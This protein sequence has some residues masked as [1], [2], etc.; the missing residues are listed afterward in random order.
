MA[1]D[2]GSVWIHYQF[3]TKSSKYFNFASNEQ[4]TVVR[5]AFQESVRLPEPFA[6]LL[7]WYLSCKPLTGF[8]LLFWSIKGQQM[9]AS[10]KPDHTCHDFKASIP[11]HHLTRGSP[12]SSQQKGSTTAKQQGNPLPSESGSVDASCVGMGICLLS[13]LSPNRFRAVDSLTF[14]SSWVTGSK[15]LKYWD[16]KQYLSSPIFKDVS[17][18]VCVCVCV[19]CKHGHKVRG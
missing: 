5:E 2:L 7:F 15:L 19:L 9:N 12:R 16:S 3:E 13:P 11:W 8:I 17:V 1:F 6:V 4:T 10:L 18:C 14:S